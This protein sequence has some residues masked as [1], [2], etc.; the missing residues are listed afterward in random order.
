[1]P[2]ANFAIVGM[3]GAMSGILYAPLTSIFL[4]A[5]A[6]GGYDLFIPL[7]MVSTISYLIVKRFSP[8]SLDVKQLVDAGQIFSRRYDR[9]LLSLLRTHDIIEKDI[10][11]IS[12]DATLR[13]LVERIKASKRNMFGVVNERQELEGVVMLDD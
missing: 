11:L 8:V 5:E 6:T 3:A 9:N 7:M 1:I 2:V 12:P 13:A 10:L 4:I